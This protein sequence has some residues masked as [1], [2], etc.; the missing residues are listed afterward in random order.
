MNPKVSA[1][2]CQNSQ[3]ILLHETCPDLRKFVKGVVLTVMSWIWAGIMVISLTYSLLNGSYSGLGTAI[4]DGATA[5]VQLC[6][7]ICGITALW[8]GIMEIIK[9]CGISKKV[10]ALLKPVIIRLLP[11]TRCNTTALE[12]ISSNISANLLG[13]GNAATPMG[14]KGMTALS[15]GSGIATND[16]C[17]LAVLNSA[18]IQ[19]IPVTIAALRGALGADSP[20]DILPAVWITS[21]ASASVG[22]IVSKLLGRHC[23]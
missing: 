17:T 8:C 3:H 9:Q 12:Y 5:A 4:I 2:Y 14:I 19:L 15:D 11:E 22:V 1:S 6:I 13:L 23:G 21:A 10:S 20:F 18:S 7:S 16:M